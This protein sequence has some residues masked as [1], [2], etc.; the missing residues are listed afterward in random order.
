MTY[1]VDVALPDGTGFVRVVDLA[2]VEL[3]PVRP[4][5]T[6]GPD[7]LAFGTR[8]SDPRAT[9]RCVVMV[10][11]SSLAIPMYIGVLIYL[12]RASVAPSVFGLTSL[13]PPM[14]FLLAA[15]AFALAQRACRTAVPRTS[16]GRLRADRLR[17][18]NRWIAVGHRLFVSAALVS[19]SVFIWAV[20]G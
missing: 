7:R 8:F 13:A 9:S 14:L 17:R 2:G 3:Y 15:A 19:I 18:R 5:G 1:N 20:M 4:D 16:T 11:A 12:G 10:S 6:R